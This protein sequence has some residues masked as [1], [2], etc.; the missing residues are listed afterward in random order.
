[1]YRDHV[2]TNTFTVEVNGVRLRVYDSARE[3]GYPPGT[4]LVFLHGSPGQISNWKHVIR[5]LKDGYRVVAYDQRG[6]GLSDKPE[7]VAMKDYID[8]LR[9][10]LR[11][12]GVDEGSAVL[13]GH[14]FGGMVA[15]E[16]AASRRVR[17]LVLIGSTTRISV[18][19]IDRVVWHLPPI[20]WRR[21]LFTE[22]PL[23]RRVYRSLFFSRA[24]PESI[25]TE[26]I[27]DNKE[28]L[29]KSPPHMFRYLKYFK[30][31]DASEILPK[32]ECPTLIIVGKEDKVTPPSESRLI[33]SLIKNS[34]LVEVED[35]G[36]LILYEKPRLIAELITSFIE[37]LK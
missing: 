13:V 34:R 21:I 28:Y 30:D 29:E 11:E 36:H 32:I 15:Q 37:S 18:D 27:R 26:F 22:N 8:D 4:V 19:I 5:I 6:Y 1:M 16:Y 17:G 35:A 23:T 14:S 3:R 25:F 12:L 20:F 7:K 24:T 9:D 10:I 31:Y 33:H 2:F